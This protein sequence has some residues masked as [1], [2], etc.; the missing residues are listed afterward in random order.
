MYRCQGT[1]K[2]HLAT[3]LGYKACQEG[4]ETRF[5]R[6]SDLVLELEQAWKDNRLDELRKSLIEFNLL[7]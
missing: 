7:P 4:M 3:V 6:V 1:G 5:W 2:T